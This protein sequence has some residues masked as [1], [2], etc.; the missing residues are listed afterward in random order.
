MQ[1]HTQWLSYGQLTAPRRASQDAW[2]R[3]LA[4]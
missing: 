4:L 1:A 2:D 3:S